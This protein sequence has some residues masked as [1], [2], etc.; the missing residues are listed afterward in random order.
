V[1]ER[2][3]EVYLASVVSLLPKQSQIERRSPFDDV[4]D[5]ELA[6]LEEDLAAVRVLINKSGSLFGRRRLTQDGLEL[7]F[8]LNHMAYFVL[9]EGLRERLL[10]S[11]AHPPAFVTVRAASRSNATSPPK[12]E[13]PPLGTNGLMSSLS[14]LLCHPKAEAAELVV[15]NELDSGLL[16]C[17]LNSD[18]S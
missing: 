5:E 7:T 11:R 12:F 17:R 14:F 9:T 16:E 13:G 1:R 15:I 8:A 6:L 3:P 2:K 4:S 10:A 18:Q